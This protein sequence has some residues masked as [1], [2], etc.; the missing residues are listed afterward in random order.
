[1]EKVILHCDLN[2]FFASVE[3]ILNPELADKPIAVCGD[4]TKRH[5]IVLAK[6]EQAKKCGVKTGD[7][8]WEAKQKCSDL[9][10]VPATHG[11]YSRYSKAVC[12][13]YYRYTDKV[14]AFGGD[15]C[16]LDIT[17]SM[18]LL[19]KSGRGL[20][21]GR[22]IADEIRETVKRELGLTLSVGVS[23]NK[24]FAKLGSDYKK[25]DATT[26]ISCDNYKQFLWLQP[27]VNMLYVGRRSR[28]LFEKLGIATIGDLAMFDAELLKTHIGINAN[29]LVA[30]ARG[31]DIG[32]VASFQKIRIVKSV[33][34][35]TTV[36]HDLKTF[37]QAEQVIY[38]LSEEVAFRM[39]KKGF[40][41][42]TIS[43]SIKSPE[44]TWVGAQ[45]SI[46][47]AT[48][49]VRTITE[50]GTKI[51]KQ[52]WHV[53]GEDMNPVRAIRVAVSN[54]TKDTRVQLSLFYDGASE[55]KNDKI[56]KIFD[57]VRRKY[58][59]ESIYYGTLHKS[60]F[61]LH[62]DVCDE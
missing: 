12:D 7:V 60:D 17:Q 26:V 5:G 51:F 34:N 36:P 56:S 28:Q 57:N 44:M 15:E 55:D 41:G 59:V 14:E 10:I 53:S 29:Y 13:I 9:V 48:N 3:V 38:L 45:E 6:S 27:V 18:K 62:F 23:W 54:L 32:E 25:P 39:R 19:G 61:N 42:F 30:C 2:N 11:V 31:E 16:W 33:G 24:T 35:G 37:R 49:S 58:G 50:N 52:L 8:I 20:D 21:G 43:L 46:R 1:M 47:E 4:P 40:K 22:E